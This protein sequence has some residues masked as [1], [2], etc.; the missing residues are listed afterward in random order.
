MNPEWNVAKEF[1][2]REMERQSNAL[3]RIEEKLDSNLLSLERR[4]TSVEI[5]VG[6][7]ASI[8]GAVTGFLSGLAVWFMGRS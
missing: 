4:V 2:T 6:R 5:H 1:L 7:K 3:E 8:L